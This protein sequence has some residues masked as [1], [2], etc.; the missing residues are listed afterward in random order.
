MKPE[1]TRKVITPIPIGTANIVEHDLPS[2]WKD[3]NDALAAGIDRLICMSH[4]PLLSTFY[5]PRPVP[6]RPLVK[7]E[8]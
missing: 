3:V 1:T 5:P 8:G 2:C 7:A 4:P 6:P